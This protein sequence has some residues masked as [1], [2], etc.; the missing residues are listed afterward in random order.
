MVKFCIN[1][2]LEKFK[3]EVIKNPQNYYFYDYWMHHKIPD[4]YDNDYVRIRYFQDL[5]DFY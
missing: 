1:E 2:N 5:E 3:M 4:Y